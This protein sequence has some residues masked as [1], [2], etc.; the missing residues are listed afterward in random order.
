MTMVTQARA[1]LVSA[2]AANRRSYR[3]TEL[4]GDEVRSVPGAFVIR[5][6][7][8]GRDAVMRHGEPDYQPSKLQAECIGQHWVNTG[9][10]LAI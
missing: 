7:G 6:Y 3:V 9:E 1:Q 5:L 10:R 2:D 8:R 4:R